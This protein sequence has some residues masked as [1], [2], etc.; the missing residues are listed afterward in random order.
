MEIGEWIKTYRLEKNLTQKQVYIKCESCRTTIGSIENCHQSGYSFLARFI[1]KYQIRPDDITLDNWKIKMPKIGRITPHERQI[2]RTAKRFPVWMPNGTEDKAMTQA[3][4]SETM[5]GATLAKLSAKPEPSQDAK[6]KGKSVLLL[7]NIKKLCQEL[8][9]LENPV[10]PQGESTVAKS[11]FEKTVD[12]LFRQ[13]NN[14][15][16]KQ[17]RLETKAQLFEQLYQDTRKLTELRIENHKS[18]LAE[19]VK[20]YDSISSSLVQL[21]NKITAQQNDISGL[22]WSLDNAF[23]FDSVPVGDVKHGT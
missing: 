20:H 3:T 23:H 5:R 19:L 14:E 17:A 22:S 2:L 10:E 13:K 15:I 7:R 12:R 16:L 1:E 11:L 21:H 4:S 6:D 8:K 18:E 9:D